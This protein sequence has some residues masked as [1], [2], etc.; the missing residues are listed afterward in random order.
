[1]PLWAIQ[2]LESVV[3]AIVQ[4]IVNAYMKKEQTPEVQAKVALHQD[5]LQTLRGKT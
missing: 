3:P 4:I 2:V 1:M 5:V